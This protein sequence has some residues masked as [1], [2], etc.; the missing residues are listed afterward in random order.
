[1]CCYNAKGDCHNVSV[2]DA[3]L[4]ATLRTTWPERDKSFGHLARRT[5]A[6]SV[7]CQYHGALNQCTY[8]ITSLHEPPSTRVRDPGI[9]RHP[10]DG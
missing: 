9:A 7:R 10:R 2:I 5:N 4:L 6:T 1:M 8:G 3:E